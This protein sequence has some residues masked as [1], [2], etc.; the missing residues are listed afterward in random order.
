MEPSKLPKDGEA[1]R[2]HPSVVSMPSP[3]E[4]YVVAL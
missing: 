2:E 4:P 3:T 1:L